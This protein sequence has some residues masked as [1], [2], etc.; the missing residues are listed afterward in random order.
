M[1]RLNKVAQ[2]YL[3]LFNLEEDNGPVDPFETGVLL[4]FAYPERIAHARPGNNAQFQLSNGKIAA[5]GHKD[6]L[7]H[8]SWLAIAHMDARDGL[9]KIF[10]ASP[11]N[12][13]DLA[14]LVKSQEVIKWDTEDGGLIATQD[15]RIGNIVLQ[16]T[17][18]PEPDEAHRVQAISEALKK[19]G[20]QLL[21]FNEQVIQW[22][23]RVLSLKKWKP[24]EGWPDVSTSTL[25]MTNNEWRLAIFREDGFYCTGFVRLNLVE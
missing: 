24:N 19:E 9:G 2:S 20:E 23:N 8:E 21:D 25:L 18:L 17:P 13:K 22:Q 14:P 16:S 11:L 15:L 5:A 1:A 10:M 4:T 6:D 12:P 3:K 7:A